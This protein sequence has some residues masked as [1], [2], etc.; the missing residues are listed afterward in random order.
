MQLYA[1]RARRA[2]AGW[3]PA[4]A[5]LCAVGGPPLHGQEDG[6]Q[7]FP[8]STGGWVVSS[9][10]VSADSS[11]IYVGVHVPTSVGQGYVLA[12]S[13]TGQ[14]K[15]QS[16]TLPHVVDSSPAIGPDGTI[17][18]GCM[19]G[20][21][22]AFDDAPTASRKAP[23]WSYDTGVFIYSSPAVAPDGTI[24][25]GAGDSALHAVNPDG[26]A[27]WPKFSTGGWIFSSPAIGPDGTVYIGSGDKNLYAVN[28]A[29]GAEKWRY[30]TGDAVDSSPA[31]GADGTIY[32]GSNDG[33]LHAVTPDGKRKW[34]FPTGGWIQASPAIGPDGT[35]Y[36]GSYDRNFYAINPDGSLKWPITLGGKATISTAAVRADGTIIVG[37]DD[38]NLRALNPADGTVKWARA[39]GDYIESSPAIA[40][41]G[42]IYVGSL[43][44]KLYAFN[45]SGSPLST[46]SSWPMFRR[47]ASHTAVKPAPPSG[48]Q[49]INL[50]TRGPVGGGANLIVGLY[51]AGTAQKSFLLRGIGPALAQ[52]P[53][54]VPGAL[55]DP[56]LRLFVPPSVQMGENDDWGTGNDPAQITAVT[57]SVGA[58]PLPAASRDA[59]VVARLEPGL[60]TAVIS[61]A[62]NSSGVGL[63]E[64]YD[65][66]AGNPG[67][68]LFNLSTRGRVGDGT[69]VLIPGLV[70]RGNG[71][72]RVLVRAVGPGLADFNVTGVLAR[73]TLNVL[74]QATGALLGTNL[75]WTTTGLQADLAA[76]ALAAG[77]FPL[78]DKSNDCALI[79]TLPNGDYT[80]PVAGVNGTTG[81]VLVEVYVLPP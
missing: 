26:T 29:D 15:W 30:P 67:A 44:T 79:L 24:Y 47:T 38:Y 76:A 43:D 56:R 3:L 75:G 11:T 13:R 9:P 41:D 7:R 71:A 20:R 73:P 66:E 48:A 36:V 78:K 58:F 5:L 25:V 55:G 1:H 74:S 39:T 19:D 17:Y 65:A 70:V 34:A 62:D 60:Y 2:F 72:V 23:R 32:V 27:K 68:R 51:V 10:A 64:A 81:E 22:Y 37:S 54:N 14:L 49:L 77:A 35:I 18:V 52:P 50:S 4:A 8:F 53:F 80:I 59:A 46:F 57:A 45:G 33:N 21:L 69:G 40:P 31:I 12:I 6:S 42:S 16:V 28:G 63:V 61:S